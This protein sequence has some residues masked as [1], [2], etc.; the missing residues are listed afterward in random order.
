MLATLKII[1]SGISNN[2]QT[3]NT[4]PFPTHPSQSIYSLQGAKQQLI[5]CRLFAFLGF[6]AMNNAY[7]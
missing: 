1:Y 4:N 2:F 6:F 5:F 7:S 3:R